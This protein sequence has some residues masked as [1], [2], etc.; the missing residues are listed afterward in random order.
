M[1]NLLCGWLFFARFVIFVVGVSL[2]A[3]NQRVKYM[4]C[5]N[6]FQTICAASHFLAE[7]RDQNP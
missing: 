2:L 7:Y 4:D 1:D 5:F 6:A 3:L